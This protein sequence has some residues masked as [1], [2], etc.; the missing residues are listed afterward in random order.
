MIESQVQSNK[1]MTGP[2]KMV[3]T[4]TIIKTLLTQ[5]LDRDHYHNYYP[6]LLNDVQEYLNY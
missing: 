5:G 1:T 6:S 4:S 2:L 3:I